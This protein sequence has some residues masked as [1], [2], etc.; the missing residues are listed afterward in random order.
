MNINQF[1]DDARSLL[2]HY[3]P[4][5][6]IDKA[7]EE[8]YECAEALQE[9]LEY[10]DKRHAIEEV[11]DCSLMMLQMCSHL[12]VAEVEAMIQQKIE[13]QKGRIENGH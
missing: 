5:H 1:N 9:H 12:G 4:R 3:G 8:C 10:S 11:A 2:K 7:I 13:R 6:Q